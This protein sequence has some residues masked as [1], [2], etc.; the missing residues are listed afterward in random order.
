MCGRF[1]LTSDGEQLQL[2]FG[3]GWSQTGITWRPRYN[4][5]PTQ[6]VLAVVQRGAERFSG[7]LRWGLVPY[8]AKDLSVGSKNINARS[9]TVGEKP[10]FKQALVRRR[11][12]VLADGF[13][14]WRKDPDG[15]RTPLWIYLALGEPFAFAGLYDVWR[16]PTG[17]RVG[18][19]TILTTTPNELME[20]IHNRM[21]V[22]LPR[23]AEGAWLNPKVGD[24]G[25]VRQLLV[26]YPAE[27]MAAYAVSDL[28]NNVKN[29]EPACIERAA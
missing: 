11:C 8:W 27:E 13:Y 26:P 19:C 4:I 20:P 21:P 15:R 7:L 28:V 17:E 5:A 1:G 12:L 22:I 6:D 24:M 9:E 14:E 23:E 10:S 2:R 25:E 3:F 16:A 29:D 18:S